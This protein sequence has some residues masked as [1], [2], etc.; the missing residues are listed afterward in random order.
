MNKEYLKE[1]LN[2][3]N[4]EL[5]DEKINKFISFK[6]ILL[7]W[8][9][10]INL[11]TITEEKE[12]YK[13]HFVDS[14]IPSKYIK[15]NSKVL[16]VGT[17]AGFPGIPLKITREDIDI[18]LLD[19]VNKKINYLNDVIK[20]LNLD[21]IQTVHSRAE[22]FAKE[23]REKFDVVISRAVANMST[24]SEYLLPFVK[25]GGT[26][27][28][29]KGPNIDEELNQA[30]KAIN[31]LGGKVQEVIEYT[32]P[33]TDLKYNLV[34]IKKERNTPKQYPRKAGKP[35]SEPIK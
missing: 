11:T 7:E 4:V 25:I 26:A 21:K 3:V 9:E 20:R 1:L 34:I 6:D 14:I 5:S 35:S 28:C 10:K 29:M 8:S 12:I 22:D 30:K 13:K 27:I 2:Q 17:G 31:I 16:D 23:N 32:I 15:E 18:T 19:A 33:D 24:L